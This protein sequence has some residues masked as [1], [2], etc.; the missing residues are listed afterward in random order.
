MDDPPQAVP[1]VLGV[2]VLF[3]G[4]GLAWAASF[5]DRI[6][7][8]QQSHRRL[9]KRAERLTAILRPV[10]GIV[11]SIWNVPNQLPQSIDIPL[12]D[13]GTFA[14]MSKGPNQYQVFD[15]VCPDPQ[16]IRLRTGGNF[17]VDAFFLFFRNA[18]NFSGTAA[19]VLNKKPFDQQRA[20][21]H[22]IV[23]PVFVPGSNVITVRWSG[24][25]Q[26]VPECGGL[27]SMVIQ[28]NDDESTGTA[29]LVV[30]E[31][32]VF[33]IPQDLPDGRCCPPCCSLPPP[34]EGYPAAPTATTASVADIAPYDL[35]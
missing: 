30:W 21:R 35:M 31:M 34:K 11:A 33:R 27:V 10:G 20:F 15:D 7:R 3:V 29:Y 1:I 14:L 13:T 17:H 12:Q 23:T 25:L 24:I 32:T 5:P 22:T 8:Q 4:A 18:A 9:Q 19:I 16:G 26:C 2:V 28:A 6:R